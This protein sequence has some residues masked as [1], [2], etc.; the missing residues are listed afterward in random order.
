MDLGGEEQGDCSRQR[1]HRTEDVRDE[2]V[3]HWRMEHLQCGHSPESQEG[4]RRRLCMLV[5]DPRLGLLA[6]FEG[7]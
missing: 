2:W 7:C 4:C 3:A 6:S 1:K 5:S